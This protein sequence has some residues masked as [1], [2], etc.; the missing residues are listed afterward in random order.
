MG[1]IQ[2]LAKQL[3]SD[4][5]HDTRGSSEHAAIDA[6]ARRPLPFAGD[7]E[8]EGGDAGSDGLREAA[9]DKTGC[10]CFCARVEGEVEWEG[11][12][13]ALGDVVDEE[14][15]ENGYA[16]LGVCVVCGVC[17]EAFGELVEGYGDGGLEAD[18][19][20]GVLRDVVMVVWGVGGC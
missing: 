9:E 14:G 6:L 15:K 7:V 5:S 8:P 2:T 4:T 16:Q 13:E 12:G 3:Q 11:H 10:H 19:E 17:D 1:Q 20:E 18:G